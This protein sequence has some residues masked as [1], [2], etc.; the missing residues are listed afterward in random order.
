MTRPYPPEKQPTNSTHDAPARP[1]IRSVALPAEHGGW[2]FLFEPVL[3]GLLIAPTLAGVCLGVAALGVFL[4]RAPLKLTIKDYRRGRRFERTRL[5]EIFTLIYAAVALGGLA[6]AFV[7]ASHPCWQP[8]LLAVPLALVQLRYEIVNRGR[9][10]LPETAGSMALACVAPMIALA[11]GMAL[12]AALLLWIILTARAVT[13]ISYVRARLRLEHGKPAQIRATWILHLLAL[14]L[15]V[16]LALNNATPWLTAAIMLLLAAR[17]CY[18]L[19]DY[20]RPA[21]PR[22]IGF[23][24]MGLGLVYIVLTAAGVHLS[25]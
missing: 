2:G 10:Y 14:A 1:S 17:A 8:F 15:L 19:S 20:R 22:V 11:G 18:G 23:Q 16:L 9:E 13:S 6:L 4:L 3:L 12:P 25:L 21:P 5:A 7:T 24:E